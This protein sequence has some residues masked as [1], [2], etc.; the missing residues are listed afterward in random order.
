MPKLIQNKKPVFLFF[1]IGFF[2]IW[3]IFGGAYYLIANI[4]NGADY[5]FEEDILLRAKSE[6]F[7]KQAGVTINHN[8]IYKLF[9]SFDNESYPME[10]PK[11]DTPRI[12]YNIDL[13]NGVNPIGNDWASYYV[14]KF[15]NLGYNFVSGEILQKEKIM[16]SKDY[17]RIK[18]KL[19]EI[20]LS[21]EEE[22]YANPI[23]LPPSYSDKI[24]RSKEFIVWV[25]S[26]VDENWYPWLNGY[27]Y[28]R[29][30]AVEQFFSLIVNYLDD[31]I[32]IV[33]SF[34]R[35]DMFIYPVIDFLYFSAVTI[36]T[37]GYGDI[38]PNSSLVR[39]F[40]MVE[41]LSGMILIALTVSYLFDW[42]KNKKRK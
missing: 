4:N 34:E 24:I 26:S 11:E 22:P 2:Y 23:T 35:N 33:E 13:R 20:D 19:Y 10:I 25:D 27:E 40:V 32:K 31:D 30:Y 21:A 18:L 17:T 29:L 42:L 12:K 14:C 16:G 9:T 36:T 6:A 39:A 38:L 5:I 3:L 7:Q 8:I 15:H 1:I 28:A 37:L 41:T